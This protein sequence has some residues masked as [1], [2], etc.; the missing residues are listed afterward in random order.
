[1]DRRPALVIF[2]C[3]FLAALGSKVVA[4]DAVLVLVVVFA[5]AVFFAKQVSP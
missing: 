4:W 2:F 5:G 1:M 3:A